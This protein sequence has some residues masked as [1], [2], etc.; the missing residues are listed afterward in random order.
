MKTAKDTKATLLA[1]ITLS[2]LT[3]TSPVLTA[4]AHADE[5]DAT[6]LRGRCPYSL[7]LQKSVEAQRAYLVK[8]ERAKAGN[9][10]PAP[11]EVAGATAEAAPMEMT[12]LP[13]AWV[14]FAWGSR[15]E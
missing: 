11:G 9:P 6:V 10:I 5:S 12:E 2:L 1:I 4:T 13:V 14:S 3:I 8:V 15:A 7:Q